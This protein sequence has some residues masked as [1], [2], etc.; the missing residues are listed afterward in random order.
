MPLILHVWSLCQLPKT[1]GVSRDW[2]FR[3]FLGV[4]WLLTVPAMC[5]IHNDLN[6][7]LYMQN[8]QWKR[9]LI[10][11]CLNWI[12]SCSCRMT[13]YVID[14]HVPEGF[15]IAEIQASHGELRHAE[16]LVFILELN[17]EIS[18]LGTSFHLDKLKDLICELPSLGIFVLTFELQ[19]S[20]GTCDDRKEKY[21]SCV[22]SAYLYRLSCSNEIKAFPY[23]GRAWDL[24]FCFVL[25]VCFNV[26]YHKSGFIE[27]RGKS[28]KVWLNKKGFLKDTLQS[29]CTCNEV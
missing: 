20:A 25:F 22:T 4:T 9:T 18:T 2:I 13:A 16:G 6:H 21:L 12:I 8:L 26:M 29:W 19:P 15:W 1:A 5:F 3:A 27:Q 11:R 24:G 7:S 28:S 10:P 23:V 14:I 17:S